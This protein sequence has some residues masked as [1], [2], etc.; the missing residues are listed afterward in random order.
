MSSALAESSIVQVVPMSGSLWTE[1]GPPCRSTIAFTIE[2]PRPLPSTPAGLEA[3]VRASTAPLMLVASS[4]FLDSAALPRIQ[5]G[6]NAHP[7]RARGVLLRRI[8]R[9][10]FAVGAFLNTRQTRKSQRLPTGPDGLS[11][12]GFFYFGR[13]ATFGSACMQVEGAFV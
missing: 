4:V 6:P 5:Q 13:W 10:G 2:S 12:P 1:I 11:P 3:V 8:V 7:V 9:P